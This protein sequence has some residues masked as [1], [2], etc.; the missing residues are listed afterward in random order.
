MGLLGDMSN[1]FDF[2]SAG[3]CFPAGDA[4]RRI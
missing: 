1:G 3:Y 2:V 4:D